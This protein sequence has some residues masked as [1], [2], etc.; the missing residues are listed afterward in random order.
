MFE[1]L[2]K[3]DLYVYLHVSV[4]NLLKNIRKRGREYE[5]QMDPLYLESIQ[6]GYFEYF[7]QVT[8]FPVLIIDTNKLDFVEHQEDYQLLKQAI[9]NRENRSGVSRI[10]LP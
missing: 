2:P 3:P 10:I 1:S 6:Q 7:R 5:Q 9:L 8:Q 4:E